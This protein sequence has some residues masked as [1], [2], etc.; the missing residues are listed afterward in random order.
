MWN[1]KMARTKNKEKIKQI[2]RIKKKYISKNDYYG[3]I[4][5]LPN[6]DTRIIKLDAQYQKN[7][8]D[9]TV[10]W[11]LDIEISNFIVP[12][13]K[14]FKKLNNGYPGD[15]TPDEWDKI[16]DEMIFAHEFNIKDDLTA[17]KSDLKRF[18][19]GMKLFSK[20]YRNLW[21]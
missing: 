1:V 18:E 4:H 13:L 10:T 16:I 17:S 20:Y 5:E 15:M 21:W 12:R 6:D 9:D 2:I 14:R 8:F 19:K 7:G 11:N 3:F